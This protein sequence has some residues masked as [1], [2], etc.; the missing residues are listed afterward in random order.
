[1][2]HVMLFLLI[3]GKAKIAQD[4]FMIL[5]NSL[6]S[7]PPPMS[8]YVIQAEAYA[9]L[10]QRFEWPKVCDVTYSFLNRRKMELSIWKNS[11]HMNQRCHCCPL[12]N[13]RLQ[14]C[15]LQ[16]RAIFSYTSFYN[17][18]VAIHY[19]WSTVE[20]TF[21]LSRYILP[22]LHQPQQALLMWVVL[23]WLPHAPQ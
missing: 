14:V 6:S 15:R 13:R 17:E 23:S 7:L 12:Q 18:L 5:M 20:K 2:T 10:N 3:V 22:Q 11:L 9:I 8:Y 1:M 21:L 16:K 4:A 19:K